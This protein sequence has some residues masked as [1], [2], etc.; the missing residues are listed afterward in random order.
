MNLKHTPF[1]ILILVFRLSI[2]GCQIGGAPKSTITPAPTVPLLAGRILLLQ[3]SEI[4]RIAG[5]FSPGSRYLAYAL[6]GSGS[7]HSGLYLYD[8]DDNVLHLTD[9]RRG[10]D[11]ELPTLWLISCQTNRQ[12]INGEPRTISW[13]P[14]GKEIAC[15][16][17]QELDVHT[18]QGLSQRTRLEN[19]D[20]YLVDL[21]P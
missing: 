14:D 19:F 8:L 5:S 3:N 10:S 15:L 17:G 21:T 1:A 7:S 11:Q 9:L 20:G 2:F 16:S 12:R 13:S 18:I 4:Y 6:T